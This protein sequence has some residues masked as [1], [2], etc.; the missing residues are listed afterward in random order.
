[1]VRVTARGLSRAATQSFAHNC[2]TARAQQWGQRHNRWRTTLNRSHTTAEQQQN[3]R[4]PEKEP[5]A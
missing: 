2:T 3:Q 5:L 4:R 1:M